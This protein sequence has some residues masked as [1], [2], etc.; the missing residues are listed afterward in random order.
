[1]DILKRIHFYLRKSSQVPTTHPV[2]VLYVPCTLS[3]FIITIPNQHP[4][5][6]KQFI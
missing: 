6:H 4:P 3:Q 1:M 2:V 5:A